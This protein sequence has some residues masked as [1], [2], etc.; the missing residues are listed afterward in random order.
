MSFPSFL[1]TTRYTRPRLPSSGSLGS[2]F[3][4]FFGTMLGY[5]CHSFFSLPYAFRSVNDTLFALF[6]VSRFRLSGEA[7]AFL[8]QNQ[9]FS[10]GRYTFDLYS[11]GNVWLSQVP[12]LPF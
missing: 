8:C 10:C 3:P 2:H 7:G 5:D 11:Q 1:S 12:G 9:V 4:T 6:F